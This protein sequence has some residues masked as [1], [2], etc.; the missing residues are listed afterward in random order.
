[1]TRLEYE[2]RPAVFQQ[3]TQDQL[4]AQYARN[5]QGLRAM[6]SR[7]IATGRKVGGYTATQLAERAARFETLSHRS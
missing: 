7:A 2:S 6:E 1:M 4:E 5:A 3:A